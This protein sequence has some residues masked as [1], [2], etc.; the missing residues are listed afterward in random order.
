MYPLLSVKPI[1]INGQSTRYSVWTPCESMISSLLL[2]TLGLEASM[3]QIPTI[4]ESM[5][6]N[7]SSEIR[8]K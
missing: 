4:K 8:V 6:G 5:I 1:F 2:G 3:E 7:A